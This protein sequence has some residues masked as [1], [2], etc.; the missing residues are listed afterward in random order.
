MGNFS[1]KQQGGETTPKSDINQTVDKMLTQL[2]DQHMEDFV[3]KQL[4]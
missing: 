2:L 3:N 4:L 1:S